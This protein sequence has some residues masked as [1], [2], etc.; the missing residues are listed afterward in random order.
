MFYRFTDKNA[1]FVT[2][3]G[4]TNNSIDYEQYDQNRRNIAVNLI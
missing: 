1:K 3:I 2:A 4:W